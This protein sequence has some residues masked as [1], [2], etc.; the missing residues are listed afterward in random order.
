VQTQCGL[1]GILSRGPF[2]CRSGYGAKPKQ[3]VVQVEVL[4]KGQQTELSPEDKAQGREGN[5]KG[6]G[7]RSRRWRD[8]PSGP[9]GE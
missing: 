2:A 4:R 5:S 6:Y 9:K 8:W 3:P 7:G 1:L